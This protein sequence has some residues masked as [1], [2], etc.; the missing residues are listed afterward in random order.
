MTEPTAVQ[1]A[2]G[3]TTCPAPPARLAWMDPARGL[4]ILAVVAYHAGGYLGLPNAVHGE[5]GV[6]AFLLVGG[7]GLAY[8]ARP[9]PGRAFLARRL[10]RLLPA[11]WVAL[12]GC[13]AFD[14]SRGTG[15]PW[16][17]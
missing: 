11:Y 14:L 10:W 13:I 8:A 16:R 4:A 2:P 5:A 6:D 3:R 9:E 1:S 7:F 17:E 15:L 12:A